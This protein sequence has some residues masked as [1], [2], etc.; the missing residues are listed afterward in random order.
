MSKCPTCNAIGV[1]GSVIA[2]GCA[3]PQTS[4]NLYN[5]LPVCQ[6]DPV[7]RVEFSQNKIPQEMQD[8]YAICK[9]CDYYTAVNGHEHCGHL[10]DRGKG[11]LLW[12][13]RGLP[14]AVSRCPIGKWTTF[15]QAKFLPYRQPPKEHFSP[16]SKKCVCTIVVGESAERNHAFTEMSHRAYA[17]RFGADYIVL[18]GATQE[19]PVYEKHRY[20]AVVEA[21][22]EGTFCVDASDTFIMPNALVSG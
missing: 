6:I 5:A 14:S 22:P 20:Q 13:V 4:K 21:Y 15:D 2:C 3:A 19:S 7:V 9:A 10:R 12:G 16:S 11:S 17:E 18:R 8:R 1:D